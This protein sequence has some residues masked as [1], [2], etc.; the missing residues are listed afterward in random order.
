[1]QQVNTKH[2]KSQ[3]KITKNQILTFGCAKKGESAKKINGI[4]TDILCDC[5]TSDKTKI[6]LTLKKIRNK[7]V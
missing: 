4:E 5:V 1:M 3:N 2:I 7:R 6:E